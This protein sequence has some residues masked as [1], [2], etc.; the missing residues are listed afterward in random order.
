MQVRC[1]ACGAVMSLDA[2]IDDGAAAQ[3]LQQ[4]LEL[5]NIGVLLIRYIALFRPAKSKLTWPRVATLLNELLPMIKA[6][7]FERDGRVVEA[8]ESA[9]MAALEKVLAARDA[10]RIKLPLTTHGYLLEIVIGEVERLHGH[11]VIVR[12]GAPDSAPTRPLSATAQ[13]MARLS[14]RRRGQQ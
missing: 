5:S 13:A 7:R 2:I 11:G 14:Q 8:Q 1:P 6:Q 3:A 10:G 4:A 12:D 9:W